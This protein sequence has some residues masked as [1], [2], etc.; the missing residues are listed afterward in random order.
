MEHSDWDDRYAAKDRL[1]S[2]D[3]NVGLVEVASALAPARALDLGSG[4]G[5]DAIW[6]AERGWN[7]TAVDFSSVAL[8]RARAHAAERGVS[9]SWVKADLSDYVPPA[10]SFD[11]VASMY[12]HL[13]PPRRRVV[14]ARAAAAVAKGGIALVLG[15]DR[16]NP[17][18]AHGPR[19]P[20]VLFTPAA[21]AAE[22]PG[23]T[24]E[25]A[26]R[27]ERPVRIEG[28]E[29]RAADTLVVARRMA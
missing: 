24:V 27:V 9:V 3:P 14:L 16:S 21:I 26:E 28:R 12:L 20:E 11:L 2:A 29:I 6:L 8:D 7:V 23:L 25:R 4:E 15:H 1:W 5:A 22:L 13:P 19:N 17:P 18:D 10:E